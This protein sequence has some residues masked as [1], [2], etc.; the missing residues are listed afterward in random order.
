MLTK[1]SDSLIQFIISYKLEK[2]KIRILNR[3]LDEKMKQFFFYNSN[4]DLLIKCVLYV[5]VNLT[6]FL[7]DYDGG[8]VGLFV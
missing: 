3:M 8:R 5:F 7:C 2:K 4:E 6:H 1:L